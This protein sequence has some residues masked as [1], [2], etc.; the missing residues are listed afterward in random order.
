M[1]CR[2]GIKIS[3]LKAHSERAAAA[4]KVNAADI[5]VRGAVE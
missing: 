4:T 3:I 5:K 2:A 1:M